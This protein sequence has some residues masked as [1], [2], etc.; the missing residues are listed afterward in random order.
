MLSWKHW[1]HQGRKHGGKRLKRKKVNL[2]RLSTEGVNRASANLD[3]MPSLEIA[4]TI[5][6]EDAKVAE[7]V[8][9]ALPQIGRAIDMIGESL[10]KGGRLIYVGAGTSGRIAALDASECPPTFNTDP[11]TVQF[12]IAGG[13]RA[14]AFAGEANEDSRELGVRE[15]AKKKPC[16]QDVVVG[17]AASGRTPFTVAA[18]QSARRSGAQTIAV[19]CNRNSPLEKAANHAIVTEVG[20]EVVSGSTRMKAG[21]AQKMVLNMLS[22]G[23]MSKLGYVYGSLMV[24]VHLKNEK[25]AERGAAILQRATGLS[26]KQVLRTLKQSRNK[27]PV[28]LVM[29]EANVSRTQAEA[30]L[31]ASGGNVRSAIAHA[32]AL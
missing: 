9:R 3:L 23:A 29:L 17:I 31:K 14:L 5:N 22:T 4:R 13:T 11:K 24:N 8:R 20:A 27:V 26:R 6:S 30:A 7:A 12:V 16:G 21:T 32:R 18:I 28:A 19:T 15:I 10:R 25:L 1:N 2:S